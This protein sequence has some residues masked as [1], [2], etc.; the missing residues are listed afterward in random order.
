MPLFAIVQLV[1]EAN[2][3]VEHRGAELRITGSFPDE[4]STK[5][6][7]DQVRKIL[8]TGATLS[9]FIYNSS[10]EDPIQALAELC[11]LIITTT[12]ATP[13]A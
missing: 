4:A 5:R 8:P 1:N 2:G 10:I 13:T 7:A 6:Y 11:N 9:L 3:V 12:G